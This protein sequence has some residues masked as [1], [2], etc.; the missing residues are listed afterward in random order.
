MAQ[1]H[2]D[3]KSGDSEVQVMLGMAYSVGYG[4][5]QDIEAAEYWLKK[6]LA[7]GNQDSLIYLNSLY[8]LE[9]KLIE[10]LNN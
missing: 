3:A 4:L 2:T 1:S 7:Q 10:I 9:G 5:P 6:A 8:T